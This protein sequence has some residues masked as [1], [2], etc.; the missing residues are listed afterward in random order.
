MPGSKSVK[1]GLKRSVFSPTSVFIIFLMGFGVPVHCYYKMIPE[2]SP[3]K[4]PNS[5]PV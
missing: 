1:N 3:G 2:N 5:L 4:N